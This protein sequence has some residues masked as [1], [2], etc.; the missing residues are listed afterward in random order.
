MPATIVSKFGGSSVADAVQIDKVRAIVERNPGRRNIVVSAPGKDDVHREKITDHLFNIAT[1]GDHFRDARK[2]ITTDQSRE[3]V[4]G[5]FQKVMAD[6][7]VEDASLLQDLKKD[8]DRGEKIRDV[9]KK[10]AFYASRGERY[11]AILISRYFTAKGMR[12][13]A[14]LPEEFGFILGG[15]P[16]DAKVQ[17]ESH[18]NIRRIQDAAFINILPGFYGVTSEGEVAVL[19]RGGSD[20]T[21]G[22]VAYAIQAERYENWTDRD[23]V[24]EAD[25]RL[26]PDCQVIPRLTFKE[27]RLL[28]STGFNV[29]HFDAMISCKK[30]Q[31]PI[32]IRNTNRPEEKGTVILNERVPEEGIVGIAMLDNMAYVYLEKDL[33]GET[34]GFTAQLLQIFQEYNINTYFYPTDKDDIAVLVNQEDLVGRINN[35]RREIEK[36]LKPDYMNVIYNQAVI[37]PVGLGLKGDSFTLMKAISI[38]GEHKIPIEMIDQ[39]PSQICFHIGLQQAVAEEAVKILH[40]NLLKRK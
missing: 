40:S 27:I 13:R 25:P 9:R 11:N 21:A 35:L 16:A 32:N 1:G 30:S 24:F 39:S 18:E 26:I 17:I 37:T 5:K 31:I 6:L 2:M 28:S 14:C 22:E 36:R 15:D 10:T 33:L 7:G 3:A 34:I 38:L 4:I 23:G 29:F 12:A 19:S 8:L 20:L